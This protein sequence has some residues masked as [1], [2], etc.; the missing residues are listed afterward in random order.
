M[1]DHNS[2][3]LLRA[4]VLEITRRVGTFIQ[5]QVTKVTAADIITKQHNSLVSYVDTTAEE[6][7]VEALKK[8][9]P[10]AA[11]ITEEDTVAQNVDA[12]LA[13]II[14]P[15]DGTTNYL[16]GIPHYSTSIALR[17]DGEV[18]LGVVNDITQDTVYHT[19]KGQGAYANK[20]KITVGKV[21]KVDEAIVVTG[22]P[23]ER[24]LDFEFS[25]NM[26]IEMLKSAR[27]VRRLGSAALD[28]AYVA[29]GKLDVYYESNLNIWDVAAGN[30][31]ISEAGGTIT[32]YTG[33]NEHLNG[34]SLVCAN[35]SLHSS[36]L[37]TIKR[38][39]ALNKQA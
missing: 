33:G 36:M 13:W 6:R 30:L 29:S 17:V 5:Q 15:I 10:D 28:L 12:P 3:E 35:A 9:L 8:I 16:K 7:I 31:L 26:L 18:V 32:G 24:D 21:D 34:H 11:F 14:D 39:K 22:F 4:E 23:Y 1:L 2:L 38:I 27:G 37:E 19:I 20:D 25:L